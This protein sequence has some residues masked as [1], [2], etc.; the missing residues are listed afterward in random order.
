MNDLEDSYFIAFGFV[1]SVGYF[2]ISL[3]VNI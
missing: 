2:L 1:M 3:G